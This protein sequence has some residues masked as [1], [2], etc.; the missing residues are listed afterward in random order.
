MLIFGKSYYHYTREPKTWALS[1]TICKLPI[2]R[3]N[4]SVLPYPSARLFLISIGL[5][6]R[7]GNT[8][9]LSP[10]SSSTVGQQLHSQHL[11]QC[12]LVQHLVNKISPYSLLLY[13]KLLSASYYRDKKTNNTKRLVVAWNQSYKYTSI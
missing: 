6:R 2:R 7:N 1:G 5:Y 9:H 10:P 3:K 4:W 11:Y 12:I 13:W 8:T